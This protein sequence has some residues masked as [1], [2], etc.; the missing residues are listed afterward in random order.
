MMSKT[1]I[2]KQLIAEYLAAPCNGVLVLLD[3]LL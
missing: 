2:M 1:D 3:Y